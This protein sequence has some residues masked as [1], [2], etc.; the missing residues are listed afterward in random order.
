MPPLTD[1]AIRLSDGRRLAYAEWGEPQGRCVFLFHGTPHS[2]LWC[3]DENVTASSNVHLVTVDRPGIGRSDVLPRR[4]FGAWPSDVV[5]LADALQVEK[6]GVVGWS[7]G[8]PYAAV[9]GARIPARLTGVGIVCS[10]HLSQFNIPENRSAA[11]ERL[12]GL[13][14]RDPSRSFTD[15]LIAERRAAA[16]A[17]T[18]TEA[19][20]GSARR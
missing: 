5:E 17:E 13:L 8:G 16:R 12:R 20:T 9:C 7:A 6:F 4:T 1:D 18:E 19:K 11:A 14:G 3:P 10:R 2:R 15:E